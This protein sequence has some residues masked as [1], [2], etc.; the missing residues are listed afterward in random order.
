[1]NDWGVG[2]V[3]VWVLIVILIMGQFYK[4]SGPQ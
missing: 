1:M 3:L 4:N 2:L